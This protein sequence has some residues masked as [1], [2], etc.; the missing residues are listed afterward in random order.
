MHIRLLGQQKA[1][2]YRRLALPSARRQRPWRLRRRERD[3][4][5]IPGPR[6]SSAMSTYLLGFY[7]LLVEIANLAPASAYWDVL[8]WSL[9]PGPRRCSAFGF[10]ETLRRQSQ[11]HRWEVMRRK[12]LTWRR[13]EPLEDQQVFKAQRCRRIL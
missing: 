13:S 1:S 4:L 11:I 5:G 10:E 9:I 6:T 7:S 12:R 8:H 3:V 2:R